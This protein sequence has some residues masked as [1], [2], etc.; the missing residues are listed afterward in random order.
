MCLHKEGNCFGFVMRGKRGAYCI[1][2]L[3]AF[4]DCLC[5]AKLSSNFFKGGFHEDWRRSR[6]L[7]VTSVRPGGP[8]DRSGYK[9]CVSPGSCHVRLLGRFAWGRLLKLDN[10]SIHVYRGV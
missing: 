4:T 9:G 5:I 10:V 1:I 2:E 7:V 6:P 8:A 3:I